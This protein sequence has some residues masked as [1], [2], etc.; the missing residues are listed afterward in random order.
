MS[1]NGQTRK[2]PPTSQDL[3][4]RVYQTVGRLLLQRLKAEAVPDPATLNLTAD[5][6]DVPPPAGST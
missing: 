2:Q 5:F 1:D 6:L 4:R 3:R